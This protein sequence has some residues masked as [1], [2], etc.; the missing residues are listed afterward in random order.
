MS[1]HC[2]ERDSVPEIVESQGI[3]AIDD[4]TPLTSFFV[5]T[6]ALLPV[7]HHR[8]MVCASAAPGNLELDSRFRK[9]E[10]KQRQALPVDSLHH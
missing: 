10:E 5:F 1:F 7:M 2:P 8:L 4:M 6:S 3:A 9:K